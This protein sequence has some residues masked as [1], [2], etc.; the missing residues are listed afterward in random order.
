MTPEMLDELMR[1]NGAT[2]DLP[3]PNYEEE[4]DNNPF[5]RGII[6]AMEASRN[7]IDLTPKQKSSAMENAIATFRIR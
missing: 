3:R 5:D 4:Q 2:S 7:L 1:E 6:K